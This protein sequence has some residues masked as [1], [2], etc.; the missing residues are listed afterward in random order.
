MGDPGLSERPLVKIMD[1]GF[2]LMVDSTDFIIK[3]LR[4]EGPLELPIDINTRTNAFIFDQRIDAADSIFGYIKIEDVEAW[5]MGGGI[6]LHQ[7]KHAQYDS[8]IVNNCIWHDFVGEYCIDPNINFPGLLKVTNSTFYNIAYGFVKN[9][10]FASDN[11]NYTE[12]PKTY[13]IDHNT[14]YNIGGKN[15]ALVQ[16]ND[17]KD[18]TVTFTFTN[19]IVEK[20]F[21]PTNVRPFRISESAGEFTFFTNVIY[22][23]MPTNPDKMQYSLDSTVAN[24]TNVTSTNEDN[25]DPQLLDVGNFLLPL[26]SPLLT[27][28]TDGGQIGDQRWGVFEGVYIYEPD[29]NV[30]TNNV[31]DIDAAI[32]IPGGDTVLNWVVD[33]DY[34]GSGGTATIVDSTGI[35]S[36]TAAGKVKVTA[37]SVADGSYFDTLIVTIQDSI[38]VTGISLRADGPAEITEYEGDIDLIATISPSDPTDPAISWSLS[39]ESLAEFY[40]RSDSTIEL[41]ALENGT[42]TVTVTTND[43][44]FTDDIDITITNQN[45]VTGVSVAVDGGGAAEIN[46]IGGTLQLVATIEP[47]DADIQTVSWVATPPSVASVQMD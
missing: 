27:A 10:D 28:D 33:N 25:N 5:G 41:V 21:D 46:S 30:Y 15:N 24:Q 31:I 16:V 32:H 7:E 14:F 40:V 4:I 12:I 45:P 20:L 23:F 35:I 3:S 26:G 44:G 29:G 19:N 18:S 42:V 47:T 2:R 8:V 34:E 22:D 37:T 13:L 9:P 39:D 38:H 11:N 36:P 43:G 1:N 17:P 6:D